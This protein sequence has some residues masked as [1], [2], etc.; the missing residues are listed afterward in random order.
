MASDRL[1]IIFMSGPGV[2]LHCSAGFFPIVILI[3]FF[4]IPKFGF[5]RWPS[6]RL[7]LAGYIQ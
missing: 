1:R 3:A 5:E 7:I 4:Y 2:K 6:F